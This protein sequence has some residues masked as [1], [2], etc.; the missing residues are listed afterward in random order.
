[1]KNDNEASDLQT[2]GQ[3]VDKLIVLCAKL[4]E[5]N[6]AIQAETAS[7]KKLH[8]ELLRQQEDIRQRVQQLLEK[9]RLLEK[10]L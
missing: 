4:D 1:M 7:L 2:L 9:L 10:T 5:R 3:Q 8:K 6:Q